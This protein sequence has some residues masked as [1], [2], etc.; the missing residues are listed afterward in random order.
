MEGGY[1]TRSGYMQYV[2]GI[3]PNVPALTTFIDIYHITYLLALHV[4][5][6]CFTTPKWSQSFFP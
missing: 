3:Q 5:G 4:H 1:E 6:P 2:Q